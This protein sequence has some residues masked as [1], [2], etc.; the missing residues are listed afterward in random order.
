MIA[1]LVSHKSF[2]FLARVMFRARFAFFFGLKDNHELAVGVEIHHGL[3][4]FLRSVGGG[5]PDLPLTPDLGITPH[6][7]RI[8]GFHLA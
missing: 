3:D 5:T 6:N 8:L 7:H 1:V 2:L 4:L